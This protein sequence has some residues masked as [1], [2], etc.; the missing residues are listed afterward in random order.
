M[1]WFSAFGLTANLQ[2]ESLAAM[3][4]EQEVP[5]MS[6]IFISDTDSCLSYKLVYI[7]YF[8]RFQV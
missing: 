1:V 6:I 8:Y 3:V 4:W 5:I 2:K 7:N